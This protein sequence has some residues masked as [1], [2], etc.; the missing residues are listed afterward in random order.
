VAPQVFEALKLALISGRLKA[1]ERYSTHSLAREFGVSPTPVRQAMLDLERLG[2]VSAEPNAGF[3]IVEPTQERLADVLELRLLIEMPV[4]SA[5]AGA[6]HGEIAERARE[7]LPIGRAIDDYAVTGDYPS[8]FAMD[9]AFHTQLIDLHGNPRITTLCDEI[10]T[11]NRLV[12][13]TS[14]DS[15][16]VDTFHQHERM[17]QLILARDRHGV[18][19]LVRDQLADAASL[20]RD[21]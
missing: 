14:M 9:T 11:V 15:F 6:C 5:I 2:V 4:L 18:E 19:A 20:W 21:H 12:I 16:S 8:Y 3:R 17:I 1:G 7:L 10:L 13:R